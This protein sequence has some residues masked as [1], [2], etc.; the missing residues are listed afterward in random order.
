MPMR[1]AD[2]LDVGY[3]TK[4]GVKNDISVFTLSK[5]KSNYHYLILER[6]QGDQVCM[7]GKVNEYWNLR[8]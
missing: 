6:L 5:W 4:R 8:F 1:L 7:C 3:E 2:G